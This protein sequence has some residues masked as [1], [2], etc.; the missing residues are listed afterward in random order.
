VLPPT[1]PVPTRTYPT[2]PAMNSGV[3]RS[4]LPS[5]RLPTRGWWTGDVLTEEG[6]TRVSAP[7]SDRTR[8][9]EAGLL[10]GDRTRAPEG[11]ILREVIPTL[12]VLR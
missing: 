2:T 6:T 11:F 4:F 8:A 7:P 9:R 1:P 5:P 3:V 10:A 12:G